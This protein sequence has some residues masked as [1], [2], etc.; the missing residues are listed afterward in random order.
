MR[1]LLIVLRL[2]PL[3]LAFWRD[4][5]RWFLL[6]APVPRTPAHHARRAETLVRRLAALGPTFVKLAQLFA[7]R[8]DILSP[9]YARAL[10]TLTDRVPTVATADVE[11]IIREEYGAGPEELF[12]RFDREPLA[13][14]SLGQVHR[15]SF[16]G[17]EVVIK[18]LRP[19]VEALVAADVRAARRIVGVV[20]RFWP[21][22][23]VIGTRVVIDEF[24]LRVAEE[25][26]F[27]LEAA[28][29]VA[30]G[31]NFAGD[32]RVWIPRVVMSMVR[33]R[34]LVLEYCAGRRIDQLDAWVAEGRVRP[35]ALVREVMELYARMMLVHGLF[36]ADPHP[37]NMHVAPDGRIILLDFGMVVRVPLELRRQLVGAIFAAIRRDPDALAASVHALGL[38]TTGADPMVIRRL[39]ATLLNVASLRTTTRERVELLAD[40]VLAELYDW[41]IIMP[42]H[43]VYFARTASLIEGLGNHY[44]THFN[45]LAFA[46]PVAMS[47]RHGIIA[48]LYPEG[49]GP[50]ID[51]ARAIGAAIG[52]V[53]RIIRRAGE[54]MAVAV[55]D[56]VAQATLPPAD[57]M[58]RPPNGSGPAG[59]TTYD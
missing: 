59:R 28:H 15:A 7:G 34:A 26:D 39:S 45:A 29:A 6:G 47:M 23:H 55:R 11:R 43:L 48:S 14:A 1:L 36:H 16:Q 4:H 31:A 3:A 5:R 57:L 49:G 9:V 52:A 41:P 33:R 10:T 24:A 19:G 20:E 32:R 35:E 42:S 27:R 2:G 17:E 12:E 54:E 38:V 21:N 51:P 37:G 8:A 56:A 50:A 40:E 53:A 58:L 18:V 22:P 25:M 13:A 30:I 44:D 46:T